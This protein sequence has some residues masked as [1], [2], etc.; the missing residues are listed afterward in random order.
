LRSPAPAPRG[1]CERVDPLSTAA[2][3][4]AASAARHKWRAH[5]TRRLSRRAHGHRGAEGGVGGHLLTPQML[6]SCS[7]RCSR[8]GGGGGAVAYILIQQRRCAGES[9]VR[10]PGEADFGSPVCS[11]RRRPR[12]CGYVATLGQQTS[13]SVSRAGMRGHDQTVRVRV[14]ITGS[15]KCRNVGESRPVPIMNG[16]IISTRTRRLTHP[17][18][19][20]SR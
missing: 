2:S 10:V 8:S 19:I 13:S 4:C 11:E 14:E 7:I 5:V 1:P 20:R 3:M 12:C 17:V 15:Q 9:V 18:G 6:H 16:P